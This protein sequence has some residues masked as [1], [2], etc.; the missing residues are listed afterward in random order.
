MRGLSPILAAALLLAI[1]AASAWAQ[2][3]PGRYAECLAQDMSTEEA[4]L[5]AYQSALDWQAAGG[6]A[7]AKHCAAIATLRLGYEEEAAARLMDLAETERFSAPELRGELLRQAASAWLL[8][9]IL[10][11]AEETATNAVNAAP[12]YDTAML[13]A[14]VRMETRDYA[15]AETDLGGALAERPGDVDA[16]I[17]RTHAHLGQGELTAALN[18]AQAAVEADPQSVDARLALG[19]AREAI[20]T[21]SSAPD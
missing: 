17:L 5:A 12:G 20:R 14:R 16:L 18:D 10:D 15:G 11:E 13:R 19:D 8:A 6:G 1:P 4:A 21:V 9:G 3:D 7:E 2:G